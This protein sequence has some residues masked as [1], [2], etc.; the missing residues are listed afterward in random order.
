MLIDMINLDPPVSKGNAYGPCD[1]VH[2]F[3]VVLT[4]LKILAQTGMRLSELIGTEDECRPSL[5]WDAFI[6]LL[7]NV[8][9]HSLSGEQA[10]AMNADS[11]VLLK[12]GT[13]KADPTGSHW[14]PF[15]VY[16]PFRWGE[17]INA[18][19]A[20][21]DL[22]RIVQVPEAD[23]KKTPVFVKHNGRKMA[24]NYLVN[25]LDAMVKAVG[26]DPKQ[27]SFH[28]ARIWLAC[29]LKE[30]GASNNRTQG[31]VRWLSEDSLRI[32]A[33]DSRHTYA[34][35]LDKAMQA[36]VDAKQVANLPT[37]DDDNAWSQLQD[38]IKLPDDD[39]N[40]IG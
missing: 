24:R 3:M 33:R 1:N 19:K 31:M 29:A 30:A 28:S 37:L 34:H 22:D 9:V 32:Y 38:W 26:K 40:V 13:A 5:R 7:E 11:C 27:F 25:T 35:W 15:P 17:P 12:V 39:P 4:L 2:D 16:L 20:I 36:N 18:A 21:M 10:T 14:A 23:R 6:Y 8:L